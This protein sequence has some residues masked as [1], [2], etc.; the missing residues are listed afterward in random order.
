MTKIGQYQIV[1]VVSLTPT[2]AVSTV[3]MPKRSGV[4]FALKQ[5]KS[6]HTD[7]DEPQW[8][9]QLFL[10]RARVQK[11]VVAAGG[12]YWLPV[13][14]MGSTKEGAWVVMDYYPLSAQKLLESHAQLGPAELHHVIQSVVKGL[15]ELQQARG[16]A[17]G[18]LKPSNIIIEPGDLSE[19][20][21]YL[22]DPA[23]GTVHN[24]AD[25]LYALGDLIYQLVMRQPFT[26]G[27]SWPVEDSSQWQR[28][29]RLAEKWRELCSDLLSPDP[30]SRPR[31][32]DVAWMIRELEKKK[33]LRLPKKVWMAPLSAGAVAAVLLFIIGAVTFASRR[34][35]TS[36]NRAWADEFATALN[37]PQRRARFDNDPWVK[38]AVGHFDAA[39]EAEKRLDSSRLSSINPLELRRTRKAAS[40][41]VAARQALSPRGWG[42][43]A[44]L[45]SLREQC[46]SR[47]WI[48]PSDYITK[49]SGT[50]SNPG[51]GFA[52]SVDRV[53][54]VEP[55]LEKAEHDIQATWQQLDSD[56]RK[57]EKTGDSTLGS[58]ARSLRRSIG[59]KVSL[60]DQGYVGLDTLA[61]NAALAA[62][63]V[64]AI[65][66]DWPGNID[67]KRLEIDAAAVMK[68]S[69][70]KTADI[71]WWLKNMPL[72][73]VRRAETSVA[74]ASLNKRLK[75]ID[76]IVAKSQPDSEDKASFDKT[77]KQV[78]ARIDTFANTPF[79]EKEFEEGVVT[80]KRTAIE[81]DLDS[82]RRFAR[83]ETV[84]DLSTNLGALATSSKRVNDYWE[85]WKQNELKDR[86]QGAERR[87]N[88]VMLK[89][90]SQEMRSLLTTLDQELPKTPDNLPAAF[91]EAG[92]THREDEIGKLL[93]SIDPKSPQ[94]DSLKFATA[95]GSVAEWGRL[96][97]KLAEDFPIKKSFVEPD[98]RPD[99]K[100]SS[101]E[102]FFNDSAIQ[103]IVKPDLERL[104]A[105]RQL[106]TANREQLVD[107]AR[108]SNRADVAFEAWRLLGTAP[109]QPAWPTG[110]QEID[111][112]RDLRHRLEP[113]LAAVP[114]EERAQPM[115]TFREQGPNRWRRAV[116]RARDEQS[117]AAAWQAR[118][119]F[120]VDANQIGAMSSAARFNLWLWRTRQE[121]S[122]QDEAALRQSTDELARASAE[123][124]DSAA[125][126]VAV[127][128][129]QPNGKAIF[130]NDPPGDRVKVA[131][132]RMGPSVE[133][134]R[135]DV[136]NGKPF[137]LA[138][139]EVS[140]GQFIAVVSATGAWN[141]CRQLPWPDAPGQPDQRRGPR[142]WE[143]TGSGGA[144]RLTMPQL[145]F[146]KEDEND[147]APSLRAERFNRMTL[148]LEAGGMPSPTHP[149]QHVSAET[150]L[151][152]ASLCGCRLPTSQEW[153]AA[154]E[155]YEKN[156]PPDQFNLRDITWEIQRQ[157][158]S[159]GKLQPAAFPFDEI[160]RDSASPSAD[161][162]TRPM[163]DGTLFFRPVDSAG[164]SVFHHLVGNVAEYLCEE[165][166]R[167]DGL[168]DG[169]SPKVIADFAAQAAGGLSVIGGSAL[170]P[171]AMPV[172]RPY[173]VPHFD[174]AYADVGFRLA[175]SAPPR[176]LAEKVKWALRGQNYL[177]PS[178]EHAEVEM[179]R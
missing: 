87:N 48:Q 49:L 85:Q 105:L 112:E 172:D 91:A 13:R 149:M 17:H 177:W 18:N 79:I 156:V 32:V 78:V 57:M 80:A 2:G 16:R 52:N 64:K 101:H 59:E 121:M 88:L 104:A 22:T 110:A 146:A 3:R 98:A 75:D 9:S 77:R 124:K 176:S 1:D 127:V 10:D 111:T 24:E 82:L 159:T 30:A 120:G 14:D 178:Q 117:L 153:Q 96:L 19:S 36:E 4:L 72:Y 134:R 116:E 90:R 131:L 163:N 164:G 126:N 132:G 69:Q 99:E 173:P 41:L 54:R 138:T 35:I 62:R 81:A 114:A 160:F 12:K 165:S 170:S 123:L 66:A 118:D 107:A 47:G 6:V 108:S 55:R 115:Q 147:F 129:S 97:P 95:A 31:L 133:F 56:T 7:P 84:K 151:W 42:R 139:T 94:L 155:K 152:F 119:A 34:Q 20:S 100:W 70:P 65:P 148:K 5:L 150:A 71:E 142:V 171:P 58:F 37:D 125:A 122:G 46:L 92:K 140:V 33:H 169:R 26:G 103:K 25:D 61:S 23:Q 53:L 11:S 83:P 136:P 73:A 93:A 137:Y 86:G 128:L 166:E 89:S 109:M 44:N 157:Y 135:V 141:E 175:I 43:V 29:G 167:F 74:A 27:E 76:E 154:Y 168:S 68:R 161:Q 60:T 50:M 102:V 145:W 40:E 45:Q 113:M 8:D 158:R 28:L 130:G 38:V 21:V 106:S 51:P 63:F 144:A 174:Q 39:R 143:W 67:T 15:V 162:Q 179:G